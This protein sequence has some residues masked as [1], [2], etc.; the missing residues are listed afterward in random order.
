VPWLVGDPGAALAEWRNRWQ[1]AMADLERRQQT[2]RDALARATADATRTR[3]TALADGYAHQ[4]RALRGLLGHLGL[5]KPADLETYI[6]LQTR[7]PSRMGIHSYDA[8][9]FRDWCWG[10]AENQASLRQVR[11][12]LAGPAPASVLVLGAGAGR[13]AYDLHQERDGDAQDS[14]RSTM[15]VEL[16]PYLTAVASRMAAGDDL[17]LVEFP[18][19]PT[20]GTTAAIQRTLE[21][22]GPAAAG[23]QV[24]LADALRAPFLSGSFDAVITPWLLDVLDASPSRV[25]TEINRVLKP[26]GRWV[27]HGSLAFNRP[28]PLENPDLDELHGLAAAA[29]FELLTAA[30]E[31][32]PYLACPDSRHARQESIVTI[33]YRKLRE[34]DALPPHANLPEWIARD[35]RPIPLLPA[36]QNQAMATRIHAFIMSLIDGERSLADLAEV[37]ESQRLMPRDDAV[38]AIR[39]F[40]IKMFDEASSSGG[41]H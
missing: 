21:S 36:F 12:A 1:M 3:L 19:A 41:Y 17:T 40:L 35:D 9:V 8:N 28:D 33:A 24:I 4:H 2:A 10:D 39:G 18:I 29:G 25:M 20:S 23:Y 15:A 14:V 6:A 11:E 34:A 16:N 30:E 31:A 37:M 26:D 5:A 27:Y 32:G 22:P 13:L 7:P 38:A